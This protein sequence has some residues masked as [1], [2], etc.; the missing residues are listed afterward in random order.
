MKMGWFFQFTSQIKSLI[1][2]KNK[3]Q[4][5]F[6]SKLDSRFIKP[7]SIQNH[8][9]SNSSLA[10]L[11]ID[12]EKQKDDINLGIGIATCNILKRLFDNGDIAQNDV[13]C[14]F[15]GVC[16]FFVKAFNYCV[17]WLPLDGSFI[18]NSVFVDFEKRNDINFDSIQEVIQSFNVINNKLIEDPSLLNTVE[19]EFMDYQAQTKDDIPSSIWEAVKLSENSYRMDVIWGYLKPRLP[20]LGEIAES[21]LVIPHSNASEE[22][23]FSII[24]KN[25]TEFRSRLDLGRSLNS[26]MRIKMSFPESLLPCHEW[27]PSDELLKKCKSATTVYNQEHCSSTSS[28]ITIFLLLP[29]NI[30]F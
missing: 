25:K 21:V 11:D 13:D 29:C 23:V 19:E 17:K 12:I 27:K 7:L 9:E 14:F 24:R 4:Q 20:H 6:M 22:R 5:R 18:K 10:T 28:E 1:N 16:D 2:I 30:Y 3:A 15:N 26:I 8:K